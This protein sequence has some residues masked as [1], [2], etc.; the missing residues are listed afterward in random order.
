LYVLLLALR[1]I[2]GNGALWIGSILKW[3]HRREWLL[4]SSIGWSMGCIAVLFYTLSVFLHGF[5]TI[6]QM[7]SFS[8]T[9]SIF[10]VSARGL[11]AS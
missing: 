9:K 11:F 8:N 6:I 1:C 10:V 7:H 4:Q 2:I 3:G 5:C